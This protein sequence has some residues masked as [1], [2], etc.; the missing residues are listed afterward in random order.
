VAAAAAAAEKRSRE[1]RREADA[2]RHAERFSAAEL[3]LADVALNAH[4][5]FDFKRHNVT[6]IEIRLGGNKL[7]Q[8]ASDIT[9]ARNAFAVSAHAIQERNKLVPV[10]EDAASRGLVKHCDYTVMRFCGAA[11]AELFED[12]AAADVCFE[13]VLDA[14]VAVTREYPIR[15]V[16]AFEQN[17]VRHEERCAVPAT[18]HEQVAKS[19]LE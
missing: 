3:L 12:R 17:S 4:A 14:A 8:H 5:G 11:S 19:A 18:S 7:L 6:C 1:A 10:H 15:D 16:A 13:L 2:Q 9:A